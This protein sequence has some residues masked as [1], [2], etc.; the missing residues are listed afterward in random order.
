MLL[1]KSLVAQTQLPTPRQPKAKTIRDICGTGSGEKS[2]AAFAVFIAQVQI[3]FAN[4]QLPDGRYSLYIDDM[5]FLSLAILAMLQPAPALKPQTVLPLSETHRRDLS[6]V[7]IFAIVASE[8]EKAVQSA[9][10]Y[11]L[12]SE[13]GRIFSGRTGERIMGET[14][15]SRDQVRDAILTAVATHQARVK[16]V[17]DPEEIVQSAMMTCLPL[18]EA[19]VPPK[20]KP[21]LNQCAAML[22]LAYEEVY[23]RE[24]LSKTAQDLKTLA[25]VLD[26]R[27]REKLKADGYSG[28]ESDV[29]LTR[30]R[31]EMLTKARRTEPAGES[32]DLDFDHCFALAAPEPRQQPGQH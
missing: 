5:K 24:K 15:Q 13:R 28:S 16:D 23:A 17:A 31:E 1:A 4:C 10:E 21:D 9:L 18:L 22:Q 26:N 20:T 29:I 3:D 7:A 14:G 19:V 27:A 32:S 8:Q 6:C 12:V 11:P 30:I 25:F 2:R